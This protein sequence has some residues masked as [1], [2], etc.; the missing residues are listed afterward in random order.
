MAQRKPDTNDT[1]NQVMKLVEQ[2]SPEQYAELRRKLDAK[3]WGQEWRELVKDV[4][5][6]NQG[7]PALSDEE[8]LAEVKAVRTEMM[9]ERARKSSS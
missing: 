6:D 3:S 9:A 7:E 4:E 1:L 5:N 8:I 2:L